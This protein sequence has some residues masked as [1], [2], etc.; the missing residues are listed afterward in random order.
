MLLW[1]AVIETCRDSGGGDYGAEE[2][3]ITDSNQQKIEYGTNR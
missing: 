3:N 2:S 1:T